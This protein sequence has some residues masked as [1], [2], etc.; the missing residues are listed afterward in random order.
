[1]SPPLPYRL[2]GALIVVGA[3]LFSVPQ[4][5]G[6]QVSDAD[7]ATAKKIYSVLTR[8]VSID[9][10]FWLK[11]S[12]EIVDYGALAGRLNALSCELKSISETIMGN[13]ETQLLMLRYSKALDATIVALRDICGNLAV[14]AKGRMETYPYERYDRDIKMYKEKAET[15]Q[16]LGRQLSIHLYGY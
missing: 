11:S 7:Y 16:E 9:D 5:P 2:F 6:S 10:E 1:M 13:S 4:A 15:Y 12:M 14:V 8:Y 3:I